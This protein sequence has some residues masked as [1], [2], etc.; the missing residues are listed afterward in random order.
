MIVEVKLGIRNLFTPSGSDQTYRLE[1]EV[2]GTVRKDDR[3]VE[4]LLLRREAFRHRLMP[5]MRNA[6]LNELKKNSW[7]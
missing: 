5:D 7:A 1:L 4:Q 2:R 6:T 3:P